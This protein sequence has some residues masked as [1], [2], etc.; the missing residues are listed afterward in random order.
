MMNRAPGI[1]ERCSYGHITNGYAHV[2]G[3]PKIRDH[4]VP[5]IDLTLEFL[6]KLDHRARGLEAVDVAARRD[7]DLV[8]DLADVR[9]GVVVLPDY[10]A[11][12]CHQAAG[13]S[14]V[15]PDP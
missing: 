11:P 12:R 15:V 2:S 3:F 14:R 8:G 13:F 10:A 6:A 7:L 4:I 9:R 1:R 5:R